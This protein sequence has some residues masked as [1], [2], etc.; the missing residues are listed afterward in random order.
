MRDHPRVKHVNAAS[1][2]LGDAVMEIRKKHKLTA[3]E[4]VML[5]N[6]RVATILKYA[7]RAERHPEDS[8]RPADIE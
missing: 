2:E 1:L 6:D 5:L 3:I 8:G 4:A 7:L